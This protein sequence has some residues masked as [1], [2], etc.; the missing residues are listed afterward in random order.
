MQGTG[1]TLRRLALLLSLTLVSTGIRP[2]GISSMAE[3][4]RSPWATR[5]SVRGMGVAVIA[6]MCGG[7]LLFI[8][9]AERCSTPNLGTGR[10]VS[11]HLR[12]GAM[13]QH[14]RMRHGSK[15]DLNIPA[16][17]QDVQA[18]T[19]SKHSATHVAMRGGGGHPGRH[20]WQDM[21][22]MMH[23]LDKRAC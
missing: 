5:A 3:C 1:F 19:L 20:F 10:L 7:G 11:L 14:P 17:A 18:G 22:R 2:T 13:E 8:A 6:S 23:G 15:A 16:C 21:R 12:H 4:A 9:S